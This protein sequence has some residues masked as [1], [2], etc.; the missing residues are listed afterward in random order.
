MT[1]AIETQPTGLGTQPQKEQAGC[2]ADP[3]AKLRLALSL[4]HTAE[5]IMRQS[6]ERR[7]PEE[8]E[9]E[10]TERLRQWYHHRP[11]AEHGDGVGRLR[12]RSAD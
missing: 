4:S 8:S 6:L 3:V 1:K 9:A 7:Y 10:I 2:G 12:R 11:G 5:R